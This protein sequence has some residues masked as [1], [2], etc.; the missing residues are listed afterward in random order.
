VTRPGPKRRKTMFRGF[1]LE[2]VLF[3]RG[4]RADP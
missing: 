1:R 3:A 2:A 4:M